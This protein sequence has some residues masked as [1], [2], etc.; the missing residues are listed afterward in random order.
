MDN[1]GPDEPSKETRQAE[2]DAI[3]KQWDQRKDATDDSPPGF[4]DQEEHD[5]FRTPDATPWR[6]MFTLAVILAAAFVMHKTWVPFSYWFNNSSQ[7]AELGSLSEKWLD[8]ARS[9]KVDSNTYLKVSGMF[10]TYRMTSEPSDSKF[11][12]PCL[13]DD[14]CDDTTF[15]KFQIATAGNTNPG[16]QKGKESHGR[17]L[18]KEDSSRNYFICPLFNIIVQTTQP[19]PE[20][21]GHRMSSTVIQKEFLP[22]IQQRKAFP[23]DLTATF[24][25]KGRLLSYEDAAPGLKD[26][27]K[28]FAMRLKKDPGE[29]WIFLD[30][31]SPDDLAFFRWVWLG[32]IVVP[33]IPLF[34]FLRALLALPWKRR[35]GRALNRTSGPEV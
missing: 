14:D 23:T 15:C 12:E 4:N 32:C 21:P 19:F 7:A 10:A 11:G 28:Q 31:Q 16:G 13:D 27:I 5:L 2:L 22:L 17:C 24:E 29:F 35:K 25:G 9:L 6:G 34:L 18:A 8:G 3:F 1:Q 26:T 33:M 30:G 20:A